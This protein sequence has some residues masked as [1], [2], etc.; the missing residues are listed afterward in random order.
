MLGRFDPVACARGWATPTLSCGAR[1]RWPPDA[2]ATPPR[3]NS[4]FRY[5][6]TRSPASRRPRPSP[7]DCQGRARYSLAAGKGPRRLVDRA[8]RAADRGRDGDRQRS[9][10]T[11]ARGPSMTSSR[12]APGCRD[13]GRECRAARI[14]AGGRARARRRAGPLHRCL[15]RATR[16]RALYSLARLRAAPG[17][18]PLIRALSD[19]DAQTRTVAARGLGKALVDSARLDFARRRC[20]LAPAAR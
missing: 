13:A 2:L 8:G 16:W 5:S 19:R 9:A 11:K 10:E 20:R 18:A 6:T 3:S 15:R 17:A 14:L 12:P 4:C 7:S 1:P